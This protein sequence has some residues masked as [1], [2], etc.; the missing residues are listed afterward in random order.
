MILMR[1]NAAGRK[2]SQQVYATGAGFGFF[3]EGRDGRKITLDRSVEPGRERV[4]EM[5][6]ALSY[7]LLNPTLRG[8]RV[9][10]QLLLL[11]FR[12]RDLAGELGVSAIELGS[13]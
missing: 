3:D 9:R 4:Q 10:R 12:A 8:C 2:K 1:M 13:Q 5:G 7:G 11:T 6:P